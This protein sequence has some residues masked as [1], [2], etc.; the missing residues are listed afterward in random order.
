M[1]LK[2]QII[3]KIFKL[4][5]F[6]LLLAV[7]LYSINLPPLKPLII[8]PAKANANQAYF[9]EN[10][11]QIDEQISF[12]A[13]LNKGVIYMETKP[14]ITYK[15]QAGYF[16]ENFLGHNESKPSGKEK[17]ATTFNHFTGD[18]HFSNIS[19]YKDVQIEKLYDGIDITLA[20]T[21][22]TIEKIF[23]VHPSADPSQIKI[24]VEGAETVGINSNGE[25]TILVQGEQFFFTAPVAF[26]NINN[27]QKNIDVSYALI[28]NKT[29]SFNIDEYDKDYPLI[30][31]PLLGL[32]YIG[33]SGDEMNTENNAHSQQMI[34]ANNAVYVTAYTDSFDFPG[35]TL[36]DPDNPP[37]PLP[38]GQ[39]EIFITKISLDLK[40]VYASTIIGSSG[41]DIYPSIASDNYG[42]IFIVAASSGNDFYTTPNAFDSSHNGNYD[43]VLSQ[44]NSN[45]DTI[46]ASTYLGGS[47][48]DDP[49]SITVSSGHVY[50]AGKTASADFPVSSDT[51]DTVYNGPGYNP[52]IARFNYNPTDPTNNFS[53]ARITLFSEY[54][55]SLALTV[56]PNNDL[57]ITGR[58][59]SGA[60]G[61]RTSEIYQHNFGGGTDTFVAR[62]DTELNLLKAFTFIGGSEIT[63]GDS[64]I[65]SRNDSIYIVSDITNANTFYGA[66]NSNPN[67]I[68]LIH[69]CPDNLLA[70][71]ITDSIYIAKFPLDLTSASVAIIGGNDFDLANSITVDYLGNIFITATT[72]SSN[73]PTT[74]GA[75]LENDPDFLETDYADLTIVK[76]NADLTELLSSTYF[77]GIYADEWAYGIHVDTQNN[78]YFTALTWSPNLLDFMPSSYIPAQYYADGADLFIAKLSNDISTTACGILTNNDDSSGNTVSQTCIEANIVQGGLYFHDTP[79]TFNFPQRFFSNQ[80]QDV[81][82][83]DNPSTPNVDV[84]TGNEDILTVADLRN[85]PAGFIVTLTASTITNGTS[86]IPLTGL[87]ATTS[88]PKYIAPADPENDLSDA[89]YGTPPNCS[90]SSQQFGGK[91]VEIAAG[92]IVSGDLVNTIHSESVTGTDP[93]AIK[94]AFLTDGAALSSPVTLM[95]STGAK[96]S[97]I[98]QALNFYLNIPAAQEPGTY[99]IIFTLDLI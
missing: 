82:S 36:Q 84:K 7:S 76:Y 31:D 48:N 69:N 25:L 39:F 94:A 64:T 18:K 55:A 44:L 81:F 54:T 17:L 58:A 77:G 51:F 3:R 37:N 16:R 66:I 41:N 10:I 38:S 33:G 5:A 86:T 72:W 70:N 1:K 73:F 14:A 32:T 46:L 40:T 87:Y 65:I 62:M 61:L 79:D 99:S 96:V 90:D 30:I 60:S 95:S 19:T 45:L 68:S 59:F 83:N 26:Q 78:I 56:A 57:Y 35:S 97:L 24:E 20:P 12:Y 9:I 74:Q 8:E 91:G 75:F 89:L 22:N 85:E 88:C 63:N 42:N 34:V 21:N 49:S 43:I 47:M 71:C 2:L 15:T 53:N 98:S 92:S 11:G 29:Y 50:I 27:K 6:S 93:T 28:D 80:E 52:F 67:T 4:T 13:R 23:T